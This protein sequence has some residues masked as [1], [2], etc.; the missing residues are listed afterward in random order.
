MYSS[1]DTKRKNKGIINVF[2]CI[3]ICRDP[4][5]LFEHEGPGICLCT[6]TNM[7]D[8]YFCI[9][10]DSMKTPE[11]QRNSRFECTLNIV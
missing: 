2:S 11:N 1:S 8:R 3:N 4:R 6:E 9:V 7:C 5:K 10:Y